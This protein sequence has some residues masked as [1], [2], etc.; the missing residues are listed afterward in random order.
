METKYLYSPRRVQ[1]TFR[2]IGNDFSQTAKTKS[3]R[4]SNRITFSTAPLRNIREDAPL[5][6]E[7]PAL[8][9]SEL[10]PIGVVDDEEDGDEEEEDEE[11][12]VDL[13]DE[14]C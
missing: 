12:D 2:A 1:T 9:S 8:G 10:D 13:L 3:R 14:N 6:E 7:L 11:D 4:S 5:V